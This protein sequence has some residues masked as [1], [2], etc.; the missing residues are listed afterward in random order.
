M[1]D[2]HL[3]Q[4][5]ATQPDK[6]PGD[7]NKYFKYVTPQEANSILLSLKKPKVLV[8]RK[9]AFTTSFKTFKESVARHCALV[10][11]LQEA[12]KKA[13]TVTTLTVVLKKIALYH[14]SHMLDKGESMQVGQHEYDNYVANLE[15]ICQNVDV[16]DDALLDV[17]GI[18]NFSYRPKQFIVSTRN[19]YKCGV[20]ETGEDYDS[21][22][23]YAGF[24]DIC[25]THLNII[26]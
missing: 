21:N 4:D 13:I 18:T 25:A 15:V 9:H 19:K 24:R 7:T 23:L 3:L 6:E 16:G 1:T 14:K 5:T 22:K 11:C 20:W 12:D 26:R 2:T 8:C 17:V 10:S